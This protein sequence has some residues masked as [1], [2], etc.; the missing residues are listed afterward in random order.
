MSFIVIDIATVVL[1][2]LER[3][4]VISILDTATFKPVSNTLKNSIRDHSEAKIHSISLSDFEVLHTCKSQGLRLSG[5]IQI[6][7]LCP[8]LNAQG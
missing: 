8:N 3:H 7:K 6:H 4:H 2:I 1:R 5:S